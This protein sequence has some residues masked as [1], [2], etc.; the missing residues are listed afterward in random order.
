VKRAGELGHTQRRAGLEKGKGKQLK[1]F[2]GFEENGRGLNVM[3]R[4]TYLDSAYEERLIS[5][6]VISRSS[7]SS[8]RS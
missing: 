3:L 7:S 6:L 8:C 5:P 4:S 2:A 1:G